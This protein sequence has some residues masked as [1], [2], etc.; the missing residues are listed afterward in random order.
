MDIGLNLPQMGS[1]AEPNSVRTAAAQAEAAGFT[2]LW[3]VDRLLAPVEPRSQYPGKLDGRLPVAQQRILDPLMTL[4]TAAAVTSTVRVGTSVLVAPWYPPAVLARSLASLD[5][6]SDG[7]LDVGLGLGWSEDEYAA[8]GR[9]MLALGRRMEEVLDVFEALW[10]GEPRAVGTG[11]E[12]VP[13]SRVLVPSQPAGPPV[14]LAAFTPAGLD[15]IA[16]RAD[17]WLCVG[18]PLGVVDQLWQ[19]TRAA[20]EQQGRD[21]AGLRLV[22]RADIDLFGRPIGAE[23]SPFTGTVQQVKGDIAHARDIG[24]DEL[25]LDLQAVAGSTDDLLERAV[26]LGTDD[27]HPARLAAVSSA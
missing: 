2:S 15:R 5:H 13:A 12:A 18:M 22:V 7:R 11:S 8:V 16:R 17:G 6:L 14:L 1:F 26:A 25:V 10:S 20:A 24:V 27:L 4:C 9:P 19:G 21:P 3:A 23:R